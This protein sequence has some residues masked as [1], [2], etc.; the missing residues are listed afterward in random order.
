MATN[1]AMTLVDR[2][3]VFFARNPEESLS[4][5][6]VSVKFGVALEDVYFSLRHA[7]EDERLKKEISGSRANG[8]VYSAGPALL[9]TIGACIPVRMDA[10]APVGGL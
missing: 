7:V 3:V 1:N 8:A 4:S 10:C 5:Q 2:V 9:T 6:D